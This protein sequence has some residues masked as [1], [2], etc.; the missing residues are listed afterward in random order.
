[1]SPGTHFFAKKLFSSQRNGNEAMHF[2]TIGELKGNEILMFSKL[3]VS[4][5]TI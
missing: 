2:K 3:F 1:M 5:L 4:L